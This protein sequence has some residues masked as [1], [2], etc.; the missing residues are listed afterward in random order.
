MDDEH[1][2]DLFVRDE[3]TV[4]ECLRRKFTSTKEMARALARQGSEFVTGFRGSRRL[5]PDGPLVHIPPMGWRLPHYKP[6]LGDFA[7][8][9]IKVSLFLRQ[10]RGRAAWKLGGLLWRLAQ[11]FSDS[12]MD[13]KIFLDGP[14]TDASS[15]TFEIV[16]SIN[17]QRWE[18]DTLSEDEVNLLIEGIGYILVGIFCCNSNS[19]L[20]FA[21]GQGVEPNTLKCHGGHILQL[22]EK[23]LLDVGFWSSACEFWFERQISSI[24]A[25]RRALLSSTQWSK[26]LE[27]QKN[28]CRAIFR[29]QKYSRSFPNQFK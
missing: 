23:T 7:V 20:N 6:D 18:A 21:L 15:S 13:D 5:T 22:T 27:S 9:K 10:P 11:Y 8:Y 4:V 12:G 19:S 3:S 26:T 25:G 28:L 17:G 1:D 24:E 14:T 2:W 16:S 29:N